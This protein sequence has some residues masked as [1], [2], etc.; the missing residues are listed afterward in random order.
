MKE[1]AFC[2]LVV[3]LFSI[4]QLCN[5]SHN[6]RHGVLHVFEKALRPSEQLITIT[7]NVSSKKKVNISAI[8]SWRATQVFITVH[9]RISS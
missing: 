1:Y 8:V 2:Y 3:I 6:H 9:T 4:F 5:V 7:F